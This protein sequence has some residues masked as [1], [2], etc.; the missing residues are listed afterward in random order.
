MNSNESTG[1]NLSWTAILLRWKKGAPPS[2]RLSGAR[3]EV[4]GGGR[5]RGSSFGKPPSLCFPLEGQARRS[6]AR[7][8]PRR[9]K[10]PR[11]SA[12]AKS[13]L[14][15]LTVPFLSRWKEHSWPEQGW[16]WLGRCTMPIREIE[17][18]RQQFFPGAGMRGWAHESCRLG[19]SP[20]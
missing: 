6:N 13:G 9:A 18:S 15:Y 17:F 1:A 4:D 10:A 12:P 5:R 8:H 11:R 20:S 3:N 19:W 16:A 7:K 2:A 14:S